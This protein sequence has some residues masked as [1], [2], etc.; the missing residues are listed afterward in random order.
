MENANEKL[1]RRKLL[2]KNE[3]NKKMKCSKNV[4]NLKNTNKKLLQKNK[5]NIKW[6][7]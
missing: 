3:E 6:K 1:G 5:E 4:I 7:C 2:Q